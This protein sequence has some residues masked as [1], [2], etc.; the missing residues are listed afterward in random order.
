[1]K[2]CILLISILLSLFITPEALAGGTHE[3]ASVFQAQYG[4]LNQKLYVSEP[5]SLYD[6]YGNIS[7]RVNYDDDYPK[8]VTPQT[9]EPI[10][11]SIQRIT[12]NLPY[13]DEQFADAVLTL[14][15]QIPYDI[16]GPKYPVET[17]VDNSGDCVALSLLAASIMKAGGLDVVLIHYTGLN[18]GHMNVGVYLPYTPVYHTSLLTPTS[19]EYDNK[20]YWTAEATPEADWKVGDQSELIASAVPVIISLENAEKASPAQVSSSL[21]TSLLPSFITLNLSHNQSS[22]EENERALTIAGSISPAYPRENVSIYISSSRNGSSYDYFQTVADD[23]GMYMMTWNFTSQGTY[24]VTASWSGTSNCAGADSDTLVVFVGPE[25]FVSFQTET[26]NYIYGKASIASYEIR[27]LQ[28]INDF[29]NIPLGENV[30]FSYDFIVLRTGHTDSNVQ[31][32]NVTMPAREITISTGRSRQTKTIEIPEKTITIPVDV[33]IDLAPLRLPDEF[34]RT[35]NNQFCFILQNNNENYSL[36]V[37]ALNDYDMASIAQDNG[38]NVAFMNTTESVEENTWYTVTENI[39]ESGITATLYG[40]DGNLIKSMATAVDTLN[41]NKMAMLIANNVDSA[42]V[43][44]DLIVQTQNSTART[45]GNTEK[46]TT[47]DGGSS[48]QYVN[49]SILLVTTFAAAIVY[50][51]KKRQIKAA[52]ISA[53]LPATRR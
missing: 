25:S 28:G 23:F 26:F 38:S 20:T 40:S 13:S 53:N 19:L 52:K 33:P 42:V 9:V 31:T 34:N 44:K 3:K 10:A 50:V 51:K 5:H 15:H 46:T 7:H 49:L 24:Y 6:Y 29:L 41:S 30:S 4:L 47:N 36:Q 8:F 22:V 11:E 17:L 27:P 1:M 45:P 21:G 35:I 16:T 12:R 18:P 39:T 32:K 48:A 14:V 43:F 2:G 37:R